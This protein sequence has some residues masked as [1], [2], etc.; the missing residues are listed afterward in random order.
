MAK[1]LVGAYSIQTSDGHNSS[2]AAGDDEWGCL[3]QS[4]Q[5]KGRWE[6]DV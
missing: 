3:L 5:S 2:A 6:I 1:I 4:A